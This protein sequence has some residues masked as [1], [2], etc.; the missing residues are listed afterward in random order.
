LF[1]ASIAPAEGAAPIESLNTYTTG[2]MNFAWYAIIAGVVLILISP[3]IRKLMG[4]V[5]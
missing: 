4:D 1:G 2:Y 5:K 3:L